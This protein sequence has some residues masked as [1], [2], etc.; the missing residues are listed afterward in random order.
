MLTITAL[1]LY[2]GGIVRGARLG[3]TE[4]SGLLRFT[5]VP[6]LRRRVPRTRR[7]QRGAADQQAARRFGTRP[8]GNEILD[9]GAGGGEESESRDSGHS[10]AQHP[11]TLGTL[12]SSRATVDEEGKKRM[13]V[14]REPGMEKGALA[15]PQ[16]RGPWW[17]QEPSAA[18]ASSAVD[19]LDG[20]APPICFSKLM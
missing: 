6:T 16:R 4:A 8:V 10:S 5:A 7:F 1:D 19:I 9:V 11:A 15:S 2:R 3:L 14:G 13:W 17:Q 20:R 18:G 12:L